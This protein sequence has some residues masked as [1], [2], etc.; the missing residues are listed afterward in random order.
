MIPIQALYSRLVVDTPSDFFP[1]SRRQL[2]AQ[3]GLDAIL[4]LPL[5]LLIPRADARQAQ[6][7]LA[8][9]VVLLK[10]GIH[11]LHQGRKGAF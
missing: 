8:H 10:C 11:R 4:K 1:Y 7:F 6:I 9:L 2:I 3:I 5:L